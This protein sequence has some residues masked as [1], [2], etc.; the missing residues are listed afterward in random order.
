MFLL[1]GTSAVVCPAAVLAWT[2][3]AAGAKVIEV[4]LEE[5]PFSAQV[6]CSLRGRA[7][8]LLPQLLR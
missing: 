1:V 4:N 8:D 2:A 6:D 3:K 7:G 5:T